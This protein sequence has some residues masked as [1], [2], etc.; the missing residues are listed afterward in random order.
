MLILFLFDG[1]FAN[2][3]DAP[4]LFTLLV[5]AETNFA[6][7]AMAFVYHVSD[8]VKVPKSFITLSY[9][10]SSANSNVTS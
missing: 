3:D 1:L 6:I 10:I 9:L 7:L 5:F 2:N 4:D 8:R